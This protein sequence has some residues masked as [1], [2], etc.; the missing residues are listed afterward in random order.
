M[1]SSMLAMNNWKQ[2]LKRLIIAQLINELANAF[3]LF[4]PVTGLQFLNNEG[5]ALYSIESKA[6]HSC[7]PNAQ[8]SFPYSNHVVK[9]IAI[10]DIQPGEEICISYLDECF[11][12]RS[13]HSRQKVFIFL[14]NIDLPAELTTLI[15][16]FR[17]GIER[18]LLVCV[19][20]PKMHR[21][22]E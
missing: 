9:L 15:F 17:V 20:V 12:E 22:K 1:N 10:Q 5:S 19:L 21:T 2:V 3:H 13:R 6:N 18:E 7:I 16:Y 8:A 4:F 14:A 11:L